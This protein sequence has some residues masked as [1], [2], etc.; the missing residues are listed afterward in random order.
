MKGITT[1]LVLTFALSLPFY[2]IAGYTDELPILILLAPGIAALIT[3]LIYQRNLRNLGWK[4]MK[5]DSQPRWWHWENSRYLALSYALPILIGIMVYGATWAFVPDSISIAGDASA[6]LVAFVTAATVGVLFL[7]ALSIGEEVA[8]RGFLLPELTKVSSF[9][10]AAAASGLVWAVWHYPLIMF[11]PGL[12]DFSGLQLYFTLPM[13]TLSLIAVSVVLGW[14]RLKTG[15][16]WPAVIAHGSHNSFT[17]TFLNDMT[18]QSGVTPYI[19]SEV[20]IGL[21]LTWTIVALVCWKIYSQ[22]PTVT[23]EASQN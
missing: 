9:P 1:F 16:V 15:S 4:L 2:V 6:T 7:A 22:S 10:I 19:A 18:V 12:F 23:T 5:T 14:I 20:G 13:F 21:L 17:L 11:A 8:W 3:R